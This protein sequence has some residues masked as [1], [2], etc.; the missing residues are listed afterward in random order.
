MV[1]GGHHLWIASTLRACGS[2]PALVLR[3]LPSSQTERLLDAALLPVGQEGRHRPLPGLAYAVHSA[4][5]MPLLDDYLRANSG[6]TPRYAT[7]QERV[8]AIGK[9]TYDTPAV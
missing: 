2:I 3:A 9:G 6:A 1:A 5:G 7:W 8:V 4:L